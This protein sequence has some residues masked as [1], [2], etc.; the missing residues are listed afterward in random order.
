MSNHERELARRLK[1]AGE[2]L[3]QQQLRNEAAE[4]VNETQEEIKTL[5]DQL[6]EE[7]KAGRRAAAEYTGSTPGCQA[8]EEN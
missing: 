3:K 5:A 6:D 1:A 8:A 4:K 2:K 7:R